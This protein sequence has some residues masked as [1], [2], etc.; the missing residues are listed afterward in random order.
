MP[1][2]IEISYQA[3]HQIDFVTINRTGTYTADQGHSPI[4]VDTAAT[5]TVIPTEAIPGHI[6]ETVNTIKEVPHDALTPVL[7]VPTMT[8]HIADCPHTGVHHLTFRTIAGHTPDQHT[9]QVR[10]PYINLHPIPAD[11][12]ANCMI[13]EIQ[14]SK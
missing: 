9:S 7:I 14:E 12:K 13:T 4:L 8:P 10:K 1:S 2:Q 6:I 11:L 3:L 5:V